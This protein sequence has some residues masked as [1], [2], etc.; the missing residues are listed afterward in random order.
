MVREA[1][2]GLV[3]T[4][5]GLSDADFM[6]GKTRFSSLGGA[7]GA[8]INQGTL[9]A[10]DGGYIA[11]LGTQVRND[12]VITA[13]LGTVALAA[14]NKVSLNFNGD[15]LVGVVVDEGA[16]NALVAN[17]GA[18]RA[19]GGLVVLT[20]KGAEGLVHTLVN[21]T[22]EVRAQTVENRAGRIYLLGEN[23][24]VEVAGSLDASA[25]GTGNGGFIETSAS[26][27]H[28]ADG[29]AITTRAASGANGTW[30]IDPTD[31]TISAGSGAQTSSGMGSS[32][33]QT[34]LGAGNV[35]IQTQAAGTAKGDINVNAPVAWSANKLT[36]EAHGDINVNAVVSASGSSTLDL[37]TGYNFNT[38]VPTFN[39]NKALNMGMNAD[40]T[41]SGRIDI[42]RTGTGLLAINN[43]GYT[44]INSVGAAGDELVA[45]SAQTLQGMARAANLTGRYALASN[46]NAS[47]T[48]GWNSGTGFVPI[49]VDDIYAPTSTAFSGAL[50]GLGHTV[51]GLRV[52]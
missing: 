45:S 47:G 41:F 30:L 6:S 4:T 10:K 27:L 7:T 9:N 21:N 19:D 14:G 17:G 1:P 34:A 37:K 3:A 32:T 52:V 44:L 25:P 23:G 42:N 40:R 18:V 39:T 28:I 38:G 8:V 46:I 2:A 22:G 35:T 43:Q 26:R 31:F 49:G 33:L 36:L 15:S 5:L 29:T 11:L 50:E 24:A 20:A 16:L 12:G 51:T 13:R 48:A